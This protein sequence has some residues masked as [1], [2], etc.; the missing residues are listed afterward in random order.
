MLTRKIQNINF[1]PEDPRPQDWNPKDPLLLT[2][3]I[4]PKQI[5]RVYIDNDDSTDIIY[6]HYIQ[7]LLE[8]WKEELKPPTSGPLVGFIG[9]SLWTLGT[10]HLSF[11]LISHDRRE[12]RT[13]TIEFYVIRHPTERNILLG[14]LT[15]FEIQVL[16]SI[17]HDIVKF[18]TWLGSA[19]IVTSSPCRQTCH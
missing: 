16:S 17:I 10:I 3:C 8:S 2:S 12:S 18:S 14:R 9:H 11:M 7:K 15:L 5:H 4:R 19:T 6:K 1:S 13:P